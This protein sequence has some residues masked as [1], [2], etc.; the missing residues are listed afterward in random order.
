MDESILMYWELRS[1]FLNDL[2]VNNNWFM[3]NLNWGSVKIPYLPMTAT[4]GSLH[5]A[6]SALS[7]MLATTV[8]K[9][10]ISGV[11]RCEVQQEKKN[12]R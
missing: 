6:L 7:E 11:K 2:E 9:E 3:M 10:E 5:S 4:S 8:T 1:S 12:G